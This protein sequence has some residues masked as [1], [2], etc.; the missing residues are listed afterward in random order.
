MTREQIK[1]KYELDDYDYDYL[2]FEWLEDY[3]EGDDI[4]D[5][6]VLISERIYIKIYRLKRLRDRIQEEYE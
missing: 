2:G 3:N 4:T 6:L 5:E 1:Q